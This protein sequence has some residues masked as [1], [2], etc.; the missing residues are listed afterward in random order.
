MD[1]AC[2]NMLSSMLLY[3]NNQSVNVFNICMYIC[4][5]AGS[6]CQKGGVHLFIIADPFIRKSFLLDLLLIFFNM[7]I[8]MHKCGHFKGVS[9]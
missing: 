8:F 7:N 9:I 4:M 5:Y 3:I 2:H 1:V 6:V